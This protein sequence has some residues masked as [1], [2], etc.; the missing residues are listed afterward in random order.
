MESSFLR[1]RE[2]ERDQSIPA[3]TLS[4][5]DHANTKREG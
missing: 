4:V 2:R 3:H 5:F 1:G